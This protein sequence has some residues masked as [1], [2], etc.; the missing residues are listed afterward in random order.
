MQ[1]QRNNNNEDENLKDSCPGNFKGD[2]KIMNDAHSRPNSPLSRIAQCIENMTHIDDV[3]DFNMISNATIPSSFCAD[4][5][6]LHSFT[7]L[8]TFSSLIKSKFYSCQLCNTRD[9]SYTFLTCMSCGLYVHRSCLSEIKLQPIY[10]DVKPNASSNSRFKLLQVCP[11]N[12]ELLQQRLSFLRKFGHYPEPQLD[13]HHN[14]KEK[15]DGLIDNKYSASQNDNHNGIDFH[16]HEVSIVSEISSA[17]DNQ[18]N[19]NEGESSLN[20]PQL[21]SSTKEIEQNID[22]KNTKDNNDDE[23]TSHEGAIIHNYDS[24]EDGHDDDDDS[25]NEY[26]WKQNGPPTQH[27][28]LSS[29]DALRGIKSGAQIRSDKDEL[30]SQGKDKAEQVNLKDTLSN[31]S[32]ALQVNFLIHLTKRPNDDGYNEEDD[33]KDVHEEDVSIPS[34]SEN[35]DQIIEKVSG[36]ISPN[37]QEPNHDETNIENVDTD[38]NKATE[39]NSIA[40]MQII[41]QQMSLEGGTKCIQHEQDSSTDS[42]GIN[43]DTILEEVKPKEVPT[44]GNKVKDT[45]TTINTT[46]DIVK[47]VK[48]TRESIGIASIAG[49]LAGGAVGLVVAGPAGAFLGSRIGSIAAGVGIL[50]EGS[51][52]IGVLVAGVKGTMFTV[53]QLQESIRGDGKNRVLTI[54]ENGTECKVVLV[55]PNILVDPI[56]ESIT[57]EI[58]KSAPKDDDKGVIPGLSFLSSSESAVAKQE[59]KKRDTVIVNSEEFEISVKEKVFLLVSSSLNDKKSLP[60]YVYRKLVEELKRRAEQKIPETVESDNMSEESCDAVRNVR[61]DVHAII[62]HITATLLEVRPGFASSPRI[63][64]LSASAVESLVFGEV[65]DLV[66]DEIKNETKQNDDLFIEKILSA[67]IDSS[68]ADFVC[69]EAINALQSLPKQHSVSEKLTCCVKL[70]ESISGQ[71]EMQNMSADSLLRIVCQHIIIANVN[72]LNAEC[73]FLE[74]FAR[75]EQLLR[76]REGYAL[77]TLQAT[78]HFLNMSSDLR[79]DVFEDE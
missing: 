53:N 12:H 27:W 33:G 50:I 6:H 19:N 70:L 52:R 74:E 20:H 48:S 55:R 69:D 43:G 11:V 7:Q 45:V 9:S 51:L 65:Y 29:P 71:G 13:S 41:A 1:Q 8:S 25:V 39:T 76:G 22:R 21:D 58:R 4:P 5:I 49:T 60:G 73:L 68:A 63:T 37:N 47:K 23:V 31:L 59:R 28:A 15:K 24:I 78:L 32:K 35:S 14:I 54:G 44:I 3:C 57:L 61:Q 77:V 66:F 30:Q 16:M 67:R 64:E 56:W 34:I 26:L 38:I 75:D 46:I 2:N 17:S 40:M 36:I 79:N 18:L 42:E 62:K 72:H 10:C